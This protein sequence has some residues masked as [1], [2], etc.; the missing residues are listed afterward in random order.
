MSFLDQLRSMRTTPQAVW[1]EFLGTYRDASF[2][3]YLFFEGKD[4][5]SFYQP[6]F[7]QLWA[8]K[9][10]PYS[11]Y[12]DGKAEVFEII[13][14]VKQKLDYE[15]RGLFF[16]DKDIDDFCGVI[17]HRDN[18]LYETECYAIENLV[19]S[20]STLAVIWTDFLSLPLSDDRYD[21][22]CRG[23]DAANELW[24]AAMTEVM[25]WVIHLRRNQHHVVL[26][27]VN[28]RK[29][30]DMDQDCKCTLKPGWAE[31]VLAASNI[32]GV[33][34]DQVAH[35]A[36]VAELKV[37]EPKTFIRGKFD[38]WFF[39]SFLTKVLEAITARIPGQP[40]VIC[41]V[42]IG[43]NTAIDVLAPRIQPPDSLKQFVRRV[44]PST[45]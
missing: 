1:L 4:D 17:L 31:H 14:R 32:T 5:I 39:V 9:G 15:W 10:T 25:A 27:G 45:T 44:L 8:H 28:L 22:I 7:R 18:Y 6:Y 26:N 30:V 21:A 29:V 43:H 35:Q 13:P 40:R 36:I 24:C 41:S 42:Q 34:Y 33:L 16:V 19:A 2:D 37:R 23:F 3:L 20:R 38:L 11:F 12:C